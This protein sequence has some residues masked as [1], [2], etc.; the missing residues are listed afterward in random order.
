M[1]DI[2]IKIIFFFR[3][4]HQTQLECNEFILRAVR[5][6]FLTNQK[7]HY[8]GIVNIVIQIKWRHLFNFDW[9]FEAWF[10]AVI[11]SRCNHKNSTN[12]LQ[13]IFMSNYLDFQQ[14]WYNIYES[15]Q[16]AMKPFLSTGRTSIQQLDYNHFADVNGIASASVWVNVWLVL[17]LFQNGYIDNQRSHA[18][19]QLN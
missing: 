10:S 13:S 6:Q 7:R 9:C 12:L 18:M 1:L 2:S 5:N 15:N 3:F 16:C 4:E 8:N 17:F 11:C 14:L 19:L